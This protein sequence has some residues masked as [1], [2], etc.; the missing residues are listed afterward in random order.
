MKS[1]VNPLCGDCG[2]QIFYRNEAGDIIRI[3]CQR[4]Y[5]KEQTEYI[6]RGLF[7]Y[8]HFVILKRE[9]GLARKCAECA[10]GEMRTEKCS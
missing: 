3:E 7:R 8:K 9:D 2:N 5:R 10:K 6:G 1:V 4:W